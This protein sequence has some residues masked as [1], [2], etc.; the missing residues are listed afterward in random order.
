[1][2]IQTKCIDV[3]KGIL[4]LYAIILLVATSYRHQANSVPEGE[5]GEGE[6]FGLFRDPK[7]GAFQ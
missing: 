1:M 4:F 6:T 5:E 2:V 3:E 7:R